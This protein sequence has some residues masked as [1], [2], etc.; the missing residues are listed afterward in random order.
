MFN[1]ILKLN[2]NEFYFII[3]ICLFWFS[4]NTGSKYINFNNLVELNSEY[5]FNLIRSILPYLILILFILKFNF[6]I[7]KIFLKKDL[8]FLS[9]F[10]YGIF[11]ILGLIFNNKNF[12]EHYWVVC[13][14]SIL[15]YFKYI[16]ETKNLF[17]VNLIFKINIFII[18]VIFVIFTFIALKENIFSYNL[19]YHSK[20]FS[21]RLADEYFPR[22]TGISRM[23]LILFFVS[24]ALY[25]VE[26]IKIKKFL[27][28]S[29]NSLLIFIIFILQSRGVILFFIISYI[30]INIIFKFKNYKERLTFYLFT[31]I[32]PLLLFFSYPVSKN[33][34]IEKYEIELD[35]FYG[36]TLDKLNFLR[37]D[38]LIKENKSD[39]SDNINAISNNRAQ[40]WNYLIQ[41]FLEGELNSEMKNK[42]I[43]LK[44]I[45]QEFHSEKKQ[46]FLFGLG[47]QADRH[48]MNLKR[49]TNKGFAKSDY[50][51]FG[52]HASNVFVYSLIC[53]G[54][55]SFI[56]IL[57]LNISILL[58]ILKIIKYRKELNPTKNYTLIVSIPIILFL[59]YRGLIENSYGVY[60]VDLIMFVSSYTV[61][62]AHLRKIDV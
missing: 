53:G 48:L 56:I 6:L 28:L 40:A 12:H 10:F 17:F 5:L 15:V 11:Q 4:I 62:V 19:L 9:L 51:P 8:L 55:L 22:A 34:F 44:Y 23:A 7:Y 60:G 45:P 24:N 61:L 16:L 46:K 52:A 36:E 18:S 26:K 35:Q 38:F 49:T 2:K 30:L 33:Y 21:F 42:I 29:I 32:F 58:K 3:A 1:N 43:N 50:G 57:I 54:F 14:F 59:M 39:L 37:D 27:F 41:I 31:I 13:L 25:F 47:P 20:S